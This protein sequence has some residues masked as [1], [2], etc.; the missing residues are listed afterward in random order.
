MAKDN[1]DQPTTTAASRSE[2]DHASFGFARLNSSLDTPALRISPAYGLGEPNAS[3]YP[4]RQMMDS[5]TAQTI[6]PTSRAGRRKKSRDVGSQTFSSGSGGFESMVRAAMPPK[7]RTAT[8][9]MPPAT[10]PV[11]KA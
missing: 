1:V 6:S 5:T 11:S 9:A 10:R 8:D 7:I 3:R 4:A 2:N